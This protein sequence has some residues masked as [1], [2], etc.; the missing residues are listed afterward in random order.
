[1]TRRL[2]TLFVLPLALTS[3]SGRPPEPAPSPS[4]LVG[5]DETIDFGDLHL[6]AVQPARMG[7]LNLVRHKRY[8]FKCRCVWT[9]EA[10]RV[11][12]VLGLSLV[13]QRSNQRPSSIATAPLRR[14]TNKTSGQPVVYEGLLKTINRNGTATMRL[15]AGKAVILERDVTISP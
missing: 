2:L 8:G 11:P 4:P 1:M 5:A 14:I 7:S 15:T 9:E 13:Q 6:D 12:N 10:T 3:C